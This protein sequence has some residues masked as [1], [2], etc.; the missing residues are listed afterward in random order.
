[1]SVGKVQP[2]GVWSKS[3]TAAN[4]KGAMKEMKKYTVKASVDVEIGHV[5]AESEEDAVQKANLFYE[6]ILRICLFNESDKRWFYQ[7]CVSGGHR[8]ECKTAAADG[9]PF[10][11]LTQS[12]DE[13]RVYTKHYKPT[14]TVIEE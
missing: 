4:R 12:S 3:T 6:D 14:V 8:E 1:M 5:L 9:K 11:K 2:S 10:C 7:H 13:N